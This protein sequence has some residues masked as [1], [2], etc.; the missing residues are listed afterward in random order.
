MVA[1]ESNANRAAGHSRSGTTTR[2]CLRDGDGFRFLFP[3]LLLTHTTISSE[4]S[5]RRS[6]A[7]EMPM[8]ITSFFMLPPEPEPPA[9]GLSAGPGGP[10]HLPLAGG[11]PEAPGTITVT[12]I[13]GG[14]ICVGEDGVPDDAGGGWRPAVLSEDV[15]G[16]PRG[17][18]CDFDPESDDAFGGGEAAPGVF[19]DDEGG[20]DLVDSCFGGDFCDVD[21][22][23]VDVDVDAAGGG[24]GE[25]RGGG[26]DGGVDDG[27]GGGGGGGE[28]LLDGGGEAGGGGDAVG[29]FCGGVAGVFDEGAGGGGDCF[30]GGGGGECCGGDGVGGGGDDEEAFG[31]GACAFGAG[32]PPA[33]DVARCSIDAAMRARGITGPPRARRCRR[34]FR[35]GEWLIRSCASIGRWGQ[36]PAG[37]RLSHR[38]GWVN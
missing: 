29:D 33:G 35:P 6:P 31:G 30:D 28:D 1:A 24:G 19:S 11:P 27:E 14:S 5:A 8:M 20:G 4:A 22:G 17:G 36:R 23:G 25:E 13:G 15:D 18:G 32:G 10:L 3:R 38:H 2:L 12:A 21:D 34:R 37:F 9:G 16:V 7:T 26:D